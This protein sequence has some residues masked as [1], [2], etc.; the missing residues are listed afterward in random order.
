MKLLYKQE[1]FERVL[2]ALEYEG[3]LIL[4]YRSSGLNESCHKG[5]IL[6]FSSLNLEKPRLRGP[7]LGYIYKEM[8]YN[9]RWVNHRKDLSDY[10]VVQENMNYLKEF[11][12]NEDVEK[13]ISDDILKDEESF[14]KYIN[15]TNKKLKCLNEYFDLSKQIKS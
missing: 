5:N 4:V 3:K 8:F 11:L 1:Y 14:R 13:T 12:K 15:E 9:S 2:F 6:P 10:P 7:V